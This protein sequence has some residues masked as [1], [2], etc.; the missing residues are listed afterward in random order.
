M[1]IPTEE[2]NNV[3]N[4][5][6]KNTKGIV[7]DNLPNKKIPQCQLK[8]EV[9][10]SYLYYA[11]YTNE[12]RYIPDVRDGQKPCQRRIIFSMFKTGLFHNKN[13][14]KC[15]S[16]AGD[17]LKYHPHGDG[18]V[19]DSLVRMVQTFNARYP[20]LEGQGNFGSIDGDNAAAH[21]YTET[22]MSIYSQLLTDDL[23][24]NTVPMV[25]NYDDSEL[26]PSILPVAVP[27]LLLNGS[28]GIAVGMTTGIPPHNFHE[29]L[30]ATVAYLKNETITIEELMEFVQGPDFP[31]AG[32][33]INKNDLLEIY[34]TGVGT[35]RMRGTYHNEK[36]QIIIDTIPYKVNKSSLLQQIM[37]SVKKHNVKG[38][39]KIWDETNH[40]KIRIVIKYNQLCCPD[41]LMKILYRYTQLQ[42]NFHCN[43]IALHGRKPVLM[44]FKDIIVHFVRARVDVIRRRYDHLLKKTR[45]QQENTFAILVVLDNLEEIIK[46]IR[47]SKDR[48][49][50][51]DILMEKSWQCNKI[52]N[53]VNKDFLRFIDINNYKFTLEQCEYILSI[54][55]QQLHMDEYEDIVK[56]MLKNYDNI[57]YYLNIISS[58]ENIKNKIIEETQEI[59]GKRWPG[60][61]R[62]SAIIQAHNDDVIYAPKE[63]VIVLVDNNDYIKRMPLSSYKTQHRGGLGKNVL[64]NNLKL[65]MVTNTQDEV[66][67]VTTREDNLCVAYPLLI[68]NIN[69]FIGN[70]AK[71]QHINS[72]INDQHQ[73]E[74]KTI[75]NPN[76]DYNYLMFVT[77]KG[78]V[79]KN[80][81]SDFRKVRKNG[82][83]VM[84]IVGE[85]KIMDI[86]GVQ[87]DDLI[88]M[89]SKKGNIILFDESNIRCF[90]STYS[91]GVRAMR[92]K[93]D[94]V[95]IKAGIAKKNMMLLTITSLGFG[96]LTDLEEY[97]IIKRGGSGV[98]LCKLQKD[99][100]IIG[101]YLCNGDEELI[102]GTKHGNIF[103]TNC[104]EIR[105]MHKNTKGVQICRV[106]DDDRVIFANVFNK[107]DDDMEDESMEELNNS[108]ME[109]ESIMIE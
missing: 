20:L 47:N 60:S 87:T 15:A 71:G 18:V 94:D 75:F 41:F 104:S 97:R 95:V 105:K 49:T 90:A 59:L 30:K 24:Y 44:S 96:K 57:N 42:S 80:D 65:A 46:I 23:D 64:E 92:L 101:A 55:L 109:E 36:D 58:E 52:V 37:D 84:K 70:K 38:I 107:I 31:T 45:R 34:K 6:L 22:K 86:F 81:I 27:M 78:T 17:V 56:Q 48:K 2:E 77:S 39:E 93:K 100:E 8:D 98:K 63:S 14:K 50:S 67:M 54:R 11:I 33:I 19:Y 28:T 16:V 43:F 51:L 13:F 10:I 103:K 4:N 29:I 3:K 73:H 25:P 102:I 1:S 7:K 89:A 88:L 61:E 9:N 85:E 5:L 74:V 35:V 40:K 26:E 91:M 62:K 53:Y 21:R 32:E 79:R 66:L 68:Y 82:K 108:L 83:Q 12:H 72:V 99:D 69:E 76:K 106:K